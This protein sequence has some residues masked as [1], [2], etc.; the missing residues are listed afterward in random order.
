MQ[1]FKEENY[2]EAIALADEVAASATR[3]HNVFE[4]IDNVTNLLHEGHWESTG[5]EDVSADYARTVKS[6]FE[7]FY[8]NVMTMKKHIYEVTGRNQEADTQA[9]ANIQ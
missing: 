1:E 3:I 9:A 4:D 8:E 2:D 6:R 5:S 7:P